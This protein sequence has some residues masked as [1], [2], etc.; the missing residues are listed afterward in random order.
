MAAT[1]KR[2]S[3]SSRSSAKSGKSTTS[4]AK[5]GTA[6]KS[7][8]RSA[9]TQTAVQRPTWLNRRVAG[10]LL[11]VV[12]L[13]LALSM[14]G[15]HGLLLDPIWTLTGGLIG[16]GI[17]VLIVMLILDALIL[18]S[19]MRPYR[20][21]ALCVFII[22]FLWSALLQC[23]IAKPLAP[24][25]G[26]VATLWKTGV[27][28]HSS[29]VISGMLAI[30]CSTAFSYT[31]A[32]IILLFFLLVC[33]FAALARTPWGLARSI[34]RLICEDNQ[35][36]RLEEEDMTVSP[37]E[38]KQ[39]K[40]KTTST[41]EPETASYWTRRRAKAKQKKAL[42][43][44]E[45]AERAK[46]E[47]AEA[48]RI[49]A[50]SDTTEIPEE[51][52]GD[53]ARRDRSHRILDRQNRLRDVMPQGTSSAT[54]TPE[55]E[56]M[57]ESKPEKT[58]KSSKSSAFPDIDRLMDWGKKQQ[59][60]ADEIASAAAEL[61]QEKKAGKAELAHA[62]KQVEQE[63]AG[64]MRQSPLPPY[65]PPSID[66]L[67]KPPRETTDSQSELEARAAQ[68]IDTLDSF[69]IDA[70]IIGDPIVG[71]TVTRFE[72]QIERG[73]KISRITSLTDDIGL[74]LG[75]PNVRISMV[76][77]KGAIG[78]EVANR[79]SKTVAFREV[80]A[81]P[82]FTYS[83]AELPVALG[84]DIT[85][86]PQ[87]IDLAKMPHLMI[88][89][90]TGSGKSVCIN[91]IL[92]SLLYKHSREELQLIMIDPKM[93]ELSNYNGIPHLLIPVVTDAK[94]ASG[95]LSWA[96][97]EMDRRYALFA[98]EG[99][100]KMEDYNNLMR[101][102]E[103]EEAE[104]A[105]AAAQT[106]AAED[107]DVPPFDV[108]TPATPEEPQTV[109]PSKVMPQIVIV[110][111]ELADLMMVSAKEVEGYIC[112]LAQ[113]ARAA[114]MYLVV[115]TQRPSADVITGLMKSNIPSRIAF[116]VASGMESRIILDTT[117]AEKLIGKGDMLYHPLGASKPIRIQGCFISTDEIE[118][119]ISHVKTTAAVE[120]SAEAQAHIEQ[121][122]SSGG[123]SHDA[124]E[125]EDPLL[126]DAIQ[127]VVS[128]G[129]ASTSLLQRR[130]K[131]GYARAA[132]VMD[133]MEER[134]IVG[135]SEGSKPRRV[136]I[137]K[138]EWMEIQ[139]RRDI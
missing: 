2:T 22:P 107:P 74:A 46:A 5:K 60:D 120:Y 68:L 121:S 55:P 26:S 42:R 65:L 82:E 90:T 25:F 103:A 1:K 30:V 102:R 116:A 135:P 96:V 47:A 117:G 43:A 126:N 50:G 54:V 115:A 36:E 87:V 92:I 95:A 139:L 66:L 108:D 69:G 79:K 134:G 7:T 28:L 113:K 13:L 130:L 104:A 111:D 122:G 4:R 70:R 73:V 125:D 18:M 93:V 77:E 128:S 98:A 129:Q 21:R 27:E 97:N 62:K 20:L 44:I 14:A 99:V 3:S 16:W 39:T 53:A 33:I 31:G 105:Q 51:F 23:I 76:P 131:L 137:T 40:Q 89:G 78:I 37:R 52:P 124:S 136:L 11:C 61:A 101:K 56:D 15:R 63:I 133:Q 24:S 35:A 49:L 100:R 91:S 85:G 9:K 81:S 57:T 48:E 119:V 59:S 75:S 8:S 86:T 41:D 118:R 72:V 67:N 10:I 19:S 34:Y 6:K 80:I 71:P 64:A 88:A 112:R 32:R 83:K 94:K 45:K 17:Y 29:G 58:A 138:D 110:I 132:R 38:A 84:K 114:G 109:K 106:A 127:I 12:A 123:S